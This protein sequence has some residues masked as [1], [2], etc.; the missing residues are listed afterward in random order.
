MFSG[1]SSGLSPVP[2]VF[3]L[4]AGFSVFLDSAGLASWPVGIP[5]CVSVGGEAGLRGWDKVQEVETRQEGRFTHHRTAVGS[6]Y[7]LSENVIKI[8][9]IHYAS[10]VVNLANSD[11]NSFAQ[12][13][14]QLLCSTS[15]LDLPPSRCA[16]VF[17][18]S[19]RNE[20]NLRG[21]LPKPHTHGWQNAIKCVDRYLSFVAKRRLARSLFYSC[22]LYTSPSPRD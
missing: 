1:V 13:D 12:M 6:G 17:Q 8:R 5:H 21:G 3:P 20:R 16:S 2:V 10:S 18:P 15:F 22:L 14:L 19:L 4:L 7:N 9:P 11:S